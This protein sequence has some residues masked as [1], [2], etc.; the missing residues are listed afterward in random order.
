[1]YLLKKK[2]EKFIEMFNMIFQSLMRP[3]KSMCDVPSGTTQGN[4][5]PCR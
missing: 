1:M 2:Y 5:P 4:L 3:R